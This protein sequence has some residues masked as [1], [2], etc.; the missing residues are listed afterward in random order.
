MRSSK[1]CP[2]S[3]GRS[4][5]SAINSIST[6]SCLLDAIIPARC[7]SR[8]W[9]CDGRLPDCIVGTRGDA[10]QGASPD[11]HFPLAAA[12]RCGRWAF[13]PGDQSW[14]APLRGAS[15]NGTLT[16]KRQTIGGT[17]RR[18]TVGHLL[19]FLPAHSRCRGPPRSGCCGRPAD[20]RRFRRR[21]CESDE[22]PPANSRGV[23][24]CASPEISRA[25]RRQL[26]GALSRYGTTSCTS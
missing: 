20:M 10:A 12:R 19:P 6:L 22:D 15:G 13:H 4:G 2:R 14:S 25:G 9:N 26:I 21:R 3:Q 16:L 17:S 18:S 24:Q 5:G 7:R 1:P 23:S 11:Q 8:Q